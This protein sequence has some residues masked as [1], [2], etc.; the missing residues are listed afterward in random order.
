MKVLVWS[1]EEGTRKELLTKAAALG[2]PVLATNE[3]MKLPDGDSMTVA[4]GLAKAVQATGADLVLVAGSKRGRDVGPRLAGHLD[5]PFAAEALSIEGGGAWKVARLVLSGNSQAT[6]DMGP[7]A[8]VTVNAGTFE[9]ADDSKAE[10]AGAVEGVAPSPVKVVGTKG[11]ETSGFSLDA[12]QVVVGVGRGFKKKEDIA[13]AEQLA[14]CFP[15]G[16]IGCSRPI[17]AD[18]KWLGED[19]WIGLSGH[20]IKPQVYFAVGVSGQIQ[21]IA[22]IRGS[23]V[24][25]AINTNKD[26]PIFQVADYGV[27]GDLYKV[28]PQLA[29]RLR[30]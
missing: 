3:L 17:A 22:G 20:E 28:L 6:Y 8:V 27:V 5:W 16:A 4:A 13:L 15:G 25:V 19:H 14:G 12:A 1:D 26:A 29:Q 2:T 7:K 10:M 24:I 9:A 21:H 23:R 18:L 11:Q 30:K